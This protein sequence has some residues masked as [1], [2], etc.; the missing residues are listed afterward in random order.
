M[1]DAPAK[2]IRFIITHPL[3]VQHHPQDVEAM[4]RHIELCGPAWPATKTPEQAAHAAQVK[5]WKIGWSG[6]AL[7]EHICPA[8][9][10][11]WR[12]NP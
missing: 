1:S 6:R 4:R 2:P 12:D 11:R 9:G 10:I 8:C 3:V 7:Y 5:F